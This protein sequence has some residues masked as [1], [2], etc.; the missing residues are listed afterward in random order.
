MA[1]YQKLTKYEIAEAQITRA[2]E[3]YMS[4]DDL[5]SA[6]TLAGAAEEILGKLVIANGGESALEEKVKQLCRMH[7]FAFS[8]TPNP[9]DYVNIRNRTRNEL[10][11]IGDGEEIEVDLEREA[12]NMIRRAKVNLLKLNPISRQKFWK[13]DKESVRRSRTL[14]HESN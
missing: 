6:I 12:V 7:E 1:N 2:L 5:I 10:K 11:H 3:L 8:E 14:E 9:K 13:F 4:S